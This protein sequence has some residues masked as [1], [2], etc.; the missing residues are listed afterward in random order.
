VTIDMLQKLCEEQAKEIKR[1]RESN[2]EWFGLC[3]TT[4]AAWE[5]WCDTPGWD[6]NEYDSVYSELNAMKELVDLAEAKP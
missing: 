2:A 5:L 3:K 4:V 6:N 1:L